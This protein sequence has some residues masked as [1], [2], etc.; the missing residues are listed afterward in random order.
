MTD[1]Y[2]WIG[3]RVKVELDDPVLTI[4]ERDVVLHGADDLGV[5]LWSESADPSGRT[6][7]V[8]WRRIKSIE[9]E[10]VKK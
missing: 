1:L 9:L 8:P 7:F 5:L 3:E 4:S 10:K 2:S 6:W